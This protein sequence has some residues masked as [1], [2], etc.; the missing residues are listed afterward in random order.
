MLLVKARDN[1]LEAGVRGRGARPLA[2]WPRIRL[3]S[4]AA[5]ASAVLRLSDDRIGQPE[6]AIA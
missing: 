1:G 2:R 6:F 5:H 3:P 4:P